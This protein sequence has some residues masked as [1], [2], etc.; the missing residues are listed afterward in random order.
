MNWRPIKTAPKDGSIFLACNTKPGF[1]KP[2]CIYW[3]D[4]SKS[5]SIAGRWRTSF[6][7]PA[8]VNRFTHWMPLPAA[9]VDDE[10]TPPSAAQAVAR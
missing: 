6:H 8:G 5:F 2:A 10:Q 3:D 7:E 9:P 1:Q 4:G